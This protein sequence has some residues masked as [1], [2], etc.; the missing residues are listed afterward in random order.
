MKIRNRITLARTVIVLLICVIVSYSVLLM[1]VATLVTE[2][3]TQTLET[4][5]ETDYLTE[6]YKSL[7]ELDSLSAINSYSAALCANENAE[8]LA[9]IRQTAENCQ[10]AVQSHF[11]RVSRYSD[12]TKYSGFIGRFHVPSAGIDVALY[13]SCEQAVVDRGDSAAVFPGTPAE[14]ASCFIAD[15]NNQDFRAL[16]QVRIGDRAYI[17][18]ADGSKTEY[19][20]TQIIQGHNTAG[21]IPYDIVDGE[22]QPVYGRTNLIAYT[23]RNGWKNILICMWD[24][25]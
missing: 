17:Q 16:P 10:N 21:G 15:H 2:C 8:E 18:Y 20:C 1:Q 6:V 12:D 22:Y 3:R 23:C 7:S 19:V 9:D 4:V 11:A 24:R 25:A 13:H 5:A 14:S